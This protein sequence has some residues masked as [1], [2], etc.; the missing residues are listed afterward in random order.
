MTW[1]PTDEELDDY[2][3]DAPSLTAEDRRRIERH[4]ETCDVCADVAAGA[5]DFSDHLNAAETWR[6]RSVAAGPPSPRRFLDEVE[7]VRISDEAADYLLANLITSPGAFEAAHI[8][9][10]PNYYTAG[11][12]RKLIKASERTRETEPEFAFV[13]A[14]AAVVVAEMLLAPHYTRELL[15]SLQGAAWRERAN[16]LRYLGRYPD[17]L[18]ACD[19][20]E[21]AFRLNGVTDFD[22]ARVTF[23]RGTILMETGHPDDALPLAHASG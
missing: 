12:V 6:A 11:V 23:I 8:T 17:A 5:L 4:L 2:V 22:I 13:L 3:I 7:K 19:R 14:N 16:A 10:D 1:H 15:H 21:A 20:A 9:D 18:E